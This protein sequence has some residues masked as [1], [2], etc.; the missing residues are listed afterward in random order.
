MT[1]LL[2]DLADPGLTAGWRSIDDGVMGGV[3]SSQLRHDPMGYAL[4]TGQVSLANGGGFASVRCQSCEL[5]RYGVAAY[6]LQVC[7]DGRQYKLSLRTDDAF[8]GINYQARFH[9]P[10]G[11]WTTCRLAPADF[12]PNWRG[13]TVPDAVPL[14]TSRV[15]Q[16]GLMIADRQAGPFALALRSV[17]VEFS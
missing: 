6:L 16:I 4:F 8:D 3:S 15:R 11:V 17:A 1:A 7:G 5:G 10:A 9:P 2:L 12:S 13:R 14:D